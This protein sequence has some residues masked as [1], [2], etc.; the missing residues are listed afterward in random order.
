[1]LTWI[2]PLKEAQAQV[3]RM[4]GRLTS[5]HQII[6]E[7]GGDPAVVDKEIAADPYPEE[8]GKDGMQ[9]QEEGQGKAPAKEVDDEKEVKEEMAA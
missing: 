2:D 3:A 4:E 9:Q 6:R 5:R 1:V 7:I 8:Y